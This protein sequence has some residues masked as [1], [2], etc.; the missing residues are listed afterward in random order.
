MATQAYTAPSSY[1]ADQGFF[2]RLAWILAAIIVIGFAQNAALGRV[3]IPA[4]PVW[5][6]FH[7][8]LMLSWLALLV[9]QNRLAAA[10][11][12]ALHR[13]LGWA[14]AFLV[15]AIVGLACFTGVMSLALHRYP[16]FFTP[17]FFLALTL[18]DT[19]AF[20]GLVFAGIANRRETEA[21]RRLMLG[22]TIIIL[23]PAF[24][25]LLPAP[26][27][28]GEMT[29][30]ITMVIQL[31]FVLAIAR[32]DRRTLGRVHPATVSV[33]IVVALAHIVVT[34]AARSPWVIALAGRI[35]GQG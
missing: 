16:P 14:G 21:H 24:G 20:G 22:A 23:E 2:V 28:G 8:L 27:L 13:R 26:I 11:N 10:G 12:L 6:H 32:H 30:W 18:T 1:R 9:T 3:N 31:G 19:M 17:S 4:V 34:L 5:V 25:R 15:C 33:G 35:A 7:G 29:E